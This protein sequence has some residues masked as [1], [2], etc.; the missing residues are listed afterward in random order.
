[1]AVGSNSINPGFDGGSSSF[2]L[3][4][5]NVM[6]AGSTGFLDQLS[7]ALI[8]GEWDVDNDGDGENDSVFIDLGLPIFTAPDGKLVRP[9][10]RANDRGSRWSL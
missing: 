1:M 8:A 6:T 10:G 7:Q 4:T 3:R 5:A 2:A 9:I